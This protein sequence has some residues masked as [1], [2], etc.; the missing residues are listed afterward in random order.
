[1]PR[2]ALYS[3]RPPERDTRP[4]RRRRGEGGRER[5]G[6]KGRE[7]DG[8]KREGR[9]RRKLKGLQK[10]N[11]DFKKDMAVEG[12][13]AVETDETRG[14]SK[15]GGGGGDALFDLRPSTHSPSAATATQAEKEEAE[16]KR[17]GQQIKDNEADKAIEV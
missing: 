15:N 1:M 13:G 8:G 4:P 17:D 12:A 6:E 9:E 16:K 7:R 11:A 3:Q 14:E 2:A 10:E 5:K